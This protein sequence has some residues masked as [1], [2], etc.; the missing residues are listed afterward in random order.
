M[1]V[2][3]RYCNETAKLVDLQFFNCQFLR[4]PK[5]KNLFDCFITSLKDLTFERLF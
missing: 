4:R 3:I 5:V 2:Q 1:D